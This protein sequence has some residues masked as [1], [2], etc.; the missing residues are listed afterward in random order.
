MIVVVLPE[1]LGPSRP[2]I[3]PR[4]ISRSRALRPGPSGG[5]RNRDRPWSGCEFRSQPP[6]KPCRRA[7][8]RGGQSWRAYEKSLR[9]TMKFGQHASQSRRP[10]T[11]KSK[12]CA[13]S[14]TLSGTR[15]QKR[16]FVRRGEFSAA[17]CGREF[18]LR[19]FRCREFV[20]IRVDRP[21]ARMAG[22][23][24]AAAN[25]L[26]TNDLRRSWATGNGVKSNVSRV[27]NHLGHETGTLVSRRTIPRSLDAKNTKPAKLRSLGSCVWTA[28]G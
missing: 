14:K 22:R 13:G 7:A 23:C 28:D 2:K 3:S 4:L 20:T 19:T 17:R 27:R 8:S 5:P 18:S 11:R 9:I 15:Q 6:S 21:F 26:F 1:P 16:K 10:P 12:G 25:L 24:W